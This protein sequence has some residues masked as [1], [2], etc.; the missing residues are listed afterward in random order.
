[1]IILLD[2]KR[3]AII[4]GV[5][6]YEDEGIPKLEGALHDANELHRRLKDPDI[7]KFEIYN[8]HILIGQEASCRGIR[9]AISDVFWQT[10]PYDLVLF[11][12]S[13]HGFRDSYENGYIAP[14]DIK[15]DEPF[16]SGI[17]MQEL[18]DTISKSKNKKVVI[19]LLDCCY[20]GIATKGDKSASLEPISKDKFEEKI[21]LS[22]E[23]RFVL[24]SGGKDQKSREI[25]GCIDNDNKMAHNHGIFTFN[26]LQGLD[27]KAA[28]N[29]GIV[30]LTKLYAYI[31]SQMPEDQKPKFSIAEGSRIN[32]ISLALS[33]TYKQTVDQLTAAIR[34][35]IDIGGIQSLNAATKRIEELENLDENNPE[36]ENLQNTINNILQPYSQTIGEW[37]TANQ[38]DQ[39]KFEMVSHGLYNYL[40]DLDQFLNFDNL[41][42]IDNLNL[43]LLSAM[44]D[45]INDNRNV[46]HFLK[47]C[48][49]CVRSHRKS[50]KISIKPTTTGSG[51]TKF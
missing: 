38:N 20:S 37:L 22:G 16:V 41:K 18:N 24:A 33:N 8:N 30:T 26:L 35:Y 3:L 28:D 32:D 6:D 10:D 31:D 1:M 7:G 50:E 49:F 21:S 25:K 4:V 17:N 45:V 27:N 36:I 5:D 14:Y 46:E 19:M 12:F 13:G 51:V 39:P 40:F 9:K 44:C 34:R 15:V 48:G 29:K 11:Y 43:C 42:D 47:R 2:G 23:G